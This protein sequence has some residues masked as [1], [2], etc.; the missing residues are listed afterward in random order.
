MKIQGKSPKNY[1]EHSSANMKQVVPLE[2][3]SIQQSHKSL[4]STSSTALFH[5]IYIAGG[6]FNVHI[7]ASSST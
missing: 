3:E 6:T 1:A 4:P 5:G 7:A 2:M